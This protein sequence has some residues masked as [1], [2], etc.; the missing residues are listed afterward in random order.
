MALIKQTTPFQCAY[1][2][3]Y[4]LRIT[5]RGIFSTYVVSVECLFC[6][7]FGLENE[8]GPK[9]EKISHIRFFTHPFR[10]DNYRQ[11][12]LQQHPNI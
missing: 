6:V 4:G 10:A 12:H 1:E 2:L 8:V 3:Q 5:Q 11:H 7:N 9:R